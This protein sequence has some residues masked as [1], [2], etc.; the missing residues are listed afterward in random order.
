MTWFIQASACTQSLLY[1]LWKWLLY[2]HHACLDVI[3]TLDVT[4]RTQ[5]HPLL[6][7]E[8]YRQLSFMNDRIQ[9]LL[10]PLSLPRCNVF[11]TQ[12]HDDKGEMKL[13]VITG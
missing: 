3:S 11:C 1:G 6:Y 8:Q 10:A 2:G 7:F 13:K 5:S 12:F 4:R 9:Y